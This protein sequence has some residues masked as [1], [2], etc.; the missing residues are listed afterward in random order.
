[1]ASQTDPDLAAHFTITRARGV[2]LFGEPI[3]AVFGDVPE[4]TYWSSIYGDAESIL[5]NISADP[6]YGV[7]NLCRVMAYRRDKRITSKREGG[8]WALENLDPR[9]HALI[10]LALQASQS[11]APSSFAWDNADMT[12]FADHVKGALS[13]PKRVWYRY[14]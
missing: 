11:E 1:M 8:R 5:D 3:D 10:R 9:F 6:V 13:P 2:C 12:A 4:S 7:L 14:A